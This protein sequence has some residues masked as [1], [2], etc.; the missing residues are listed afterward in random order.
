MNKV[1]YRTFVKETGLAEMR[2]SDIL[3]RL[4]GCLIN[5]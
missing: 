3:L 4:T 1:G 2:L 5:Y